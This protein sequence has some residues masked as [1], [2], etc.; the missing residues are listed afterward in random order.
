MVADMCICEAA[1]EARFFSMVMRLAQ[2]LAFHTRSPARRAELDAVVVLE[3]R[4]SVPETPERAVVQDVPAEACIAPLAQPAADPL[5]AAS[6]RYN[7]GSG[8]TSAVLF[9]NT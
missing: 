8:N 5:S 4:C 3:S 9:E 6:A 2:P 1:C 7:E